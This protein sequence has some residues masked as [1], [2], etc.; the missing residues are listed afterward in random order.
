MHKESNIQVW[1]TLYLLLYHV[2]VPG[3]T[4]RQQR[5]EAQYQAIRESYKELGSLAEVGRKFGMSRQRVHQIMNKEVK[6]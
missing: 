6:K 5:L 1:I 2:N 3:M 4:P